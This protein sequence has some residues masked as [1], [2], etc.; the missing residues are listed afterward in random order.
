[1]SDAFKKL[2]EFRDYLPGAKQD[3]PQERVDFY[4]IKELESHNRE[5]LAA[6][7][8]MREALQEIT[9]LHGSTMNFGVARHMADNAIKSSGEVTLLQSNIEDNKTVL[10]INALLVYPLDSKLYTIQTKS[11]AEG[12]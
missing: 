10:L 7:Q 6:N 8:V 12:G 11:N 4:R 1:M 9:T 3:T 2:L 5:L